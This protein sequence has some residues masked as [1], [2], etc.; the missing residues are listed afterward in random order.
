MIRPAEGS[1]F[2][3]SLFSEEE[4]MVLESVKEFVQREVQPLAEE[5][6]HQNEHSRSVA[7]LEKAGELGL[8]GLGISEEYGGMPVSF[9]TSLKVVE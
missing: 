1:N 2:P 9:T 3:D 7:L 6:V 8:L 4:Q 5:L